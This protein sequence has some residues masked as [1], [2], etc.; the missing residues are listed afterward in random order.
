LKDFATVIA[1]D[2]SNS[3]ETLAYWGLN[4]PSS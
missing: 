1:E 3:L 4:K 2:S